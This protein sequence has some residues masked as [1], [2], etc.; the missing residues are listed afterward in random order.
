M[1]DIIRVEVRE[2]SPRLGAAMRELMLALLEETNW[3]GAQVTFDHI[4]TEKC[5]VYLHVKVGGK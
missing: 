3:E 5:T 1:Q 4:R 2:T